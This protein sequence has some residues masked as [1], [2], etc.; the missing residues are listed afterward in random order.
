MAKQWPTVV[1]DGGRNAA[2]SAHKGELARARME[3]SNHGPTGTS[4]GQSE[5]VFNLTIDPWPYAPEDPKIELKKKDKGLHRGACVRPGGIAARSARMQRVEGVAK[6][7]AEKKPTGQRPREGGW[8]HEDMRTR[9][10][11]GEG[12]GSAANIA[13]KGRVNFQNSREH[14]EQARTPAERLRG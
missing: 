7:V 12:R 4:G 11:K 10:R 9:T 6:P 1:S 2:R 14:A 13:L 5:V 8:S 3:C